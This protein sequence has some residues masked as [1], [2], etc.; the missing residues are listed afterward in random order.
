MG[1]L[2]LG[3]IWSAGYYL[4]C[5]ASNLERSDRNPFTVRAL[6]KLAMFYLA[7]FRLRKALQ[8]LRR[9]EAIA[10]EHEI[11]GQLLPLETLLR[12]LEMLDW[13]GWF[14]RRRVGA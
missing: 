3:R 12:R 14:R 5:G 6:R 8:A 2:R 13:R 4:T 1:Y 9:A 10:R 7:T 11:R